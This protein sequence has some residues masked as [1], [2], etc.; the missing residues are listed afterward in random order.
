[1]EIVLLVTA[2]ALMLL[3]PRGLPLWA[4][5]VSCALIGLASTLISPS[6]A[7]SALGTLRDPLLFLVV[8]VPLAVSLDDLG[9][10]VSIAARFSDSRHLIARLWWLAA[11]VV[12][13]FNLDAAVVLLTPLYIR[14][15]RRHGLPIEALAFQPAL[16]ACIGSGVLPVSNLTNLIVAAQWDL[17]ATDFLTHLAIPCVAASA[18]GYIAYRRVFDFGVTATPL[19]VHADDRALRRGLPVIAFVLLGFTIGDSVGIPAWGVSAVALVWVTSL[20]RRLPWRSVPVVA[21]ATAAS[22]AVLVAG[23]IPHLGLE[24]IFD[25]S[26]ASGDLGIVAFGALG[27]SVAN[28]LPVVLAGSAAMRT[29]DQAW[30]LLVGSNIGSV[31]LVTASLSGLLWRDTAARAGVQ[32]TGRRYTAVGVRVGLPAIAVATALVLFA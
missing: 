28:N 20:T 22:L 29:A 2:S 10:F 24:R 11:A 23:A 16:L 6:A 32:V 14:I 9:V 31:F 25:R 5:P 13:V 18:V 30:P 27:S 12:A 15:A 7:S 4:G 19:A 26:G 3:C 8:A 21:I 1:M 17:S